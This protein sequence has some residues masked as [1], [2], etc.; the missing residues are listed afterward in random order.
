MISHYF[1]HVTKH[2]PLRVRV[3]TPEDDGPCSECGPQV[4]RHSRFA[5]PF[6]VKLKELLLSKKRHVF[7]SWFFFLDSESALVT[8]A[9]WRAPHDG[10]R[11]AAQQARAGNLKVKSFE[12]ILGRVA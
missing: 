10:R 12:P 4:V 7:S 3:E 9:A 5:G 8:A 1:Q 6:N 11:G 2:L